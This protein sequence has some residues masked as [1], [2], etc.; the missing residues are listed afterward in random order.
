MIP[1]CEMQAMN[2]K[3]VMICVGIIFVSWNFLEA[4][5]LKRAIVIGASSGMGKE[6]A[7]LLA[8]DGYVVG[9]VGRREDCLQQLKKEILTPT[10]VKQL[11]AADTEKA[12]KTLQELIEEMGGLDLL[13]ITISGFRDA[14]ASERDW[15]NN[16]IFL[17]VDVRGF[18]AL[19]RTG[20]N[21][22]EKQG[23]GH[24]VGFSSIDGLRGIAA[25]PIYSAAKA[26]CSRYMEAE[27]NYFIQKHL[28][29]IVTEIIPGWINSLEDPDFQRNNPHAYWFESLHD[30]SHEI[31]QAIK[32]KESVA[33]ITKRWKQVA[34]MI[35]VM[36]DELYNA[37]GGI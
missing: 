26:F 6:V 30:A 17:N 4:E 21:F 25:T 11:D 36:P 18:F 19:A 34:D 16:E 23:Y 27:R 28:P 7:K 20:F 5:N 9:L 32:N 31:F 3:I 35:K 2:M 15:K 14:I 8:A 29:V 24:F 22:F 12:V 1:I 10:Y 33:Y 37:L 13:V